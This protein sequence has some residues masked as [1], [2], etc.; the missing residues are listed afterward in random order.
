[1]IEERGQRAREV[2]LTSD[3]KLMQSLHVVLSISIDATNSDFEMGLRPR[4]KQIVIRK[5]GL[6]LGLGLDP[7]LILGRI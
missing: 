5:M 7:A 3:E 4:A 6:G 1:M 2:R